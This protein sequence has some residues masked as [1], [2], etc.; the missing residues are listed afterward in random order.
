M[1]I[2]LL[3]IRTS[4]GKSTVINAMLKDRV[5]PSGIGHTT[6]C[7][8][9]VEGTDEDEAYLITEASTERRSVTVSEA[10]ETSARVPAVITV[11]VT[12]ALAC[13]DDS[14]P[15]SSSDGEPAGS[16][17]PHGSHSGLG[18]IGQSLLA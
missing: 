6:N 2:H 11:L 9:S 18:Y 16:C 17:S 5:L 10:A 12:C 8:L 4:N 15:P 14:L 7:F 13:G 1:I 3:W